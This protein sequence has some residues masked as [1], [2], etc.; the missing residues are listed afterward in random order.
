MIRRF[1]C[2]TRSPGLVA[3]P[4]IAALVPGSVTPVLQGASNV[5]GLRSTTASWTAS[6]PDNWFKPASYSLSN[7]IVPELQ[8]MTGYVPAAIHAAK[9]C[10][11]ITID[12]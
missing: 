2:I 4:S 10:H 12:L 1:R 7:G 11:F 3:G 5:A 8:R 6:S 9:P